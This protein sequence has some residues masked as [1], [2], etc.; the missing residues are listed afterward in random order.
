[1]ISE[2]L[3]ATLGY[4]VGS[5]SFGNLASR[6]LPVPELEQLRSDGA[7]ASTVYRF[8]GSRAFF[9]VML[10]DFSKSALIVSLCHWLLSPNAAMIAG[11]GAV[12]GNNWPVFHGFKG[13]RGVAAAAGAL[14]ALVPVPFGLSLIPA[15]FLFT[16][17]RNVTLA[18]LGLFW[19]TAALT[20]TMA[21]STA[22]AVYITVLPA[23]VAAYT[24]GARRHVP[25]GE[26]WR[27]TFMRSSNVRPV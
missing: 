8:R 20:W 1:M 21:Y 22:L 11:I 17:T 12:A 2:L 9:V 25:L 5:I 19:T 7:G 10:G 26:R 14:T 6:G 4:I 16:L 15:F 13:G 3:A 24:L 23:A 18:S 27:T